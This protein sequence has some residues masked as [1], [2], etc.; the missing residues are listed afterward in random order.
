MPYLLFNNQLIHNETQEDDCLLLRVDK[1]KL[2]EV[3]L[4]LS[5]LVT[6]LGNCEY[7]FGGT[8]N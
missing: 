8:R 7:D 4:R 3:H 2:E 6:E 5:V 1:K